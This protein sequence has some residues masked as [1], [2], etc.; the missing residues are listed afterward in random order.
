MYI[1]CVYLTEYTEKCPISPEEKLEKNDSILKPPEI[2]EYL[3]IPL[4]TLYKL[5]NEGKVPATR[6][7]KHWRFRKKEIDKWFAENNVVGKRD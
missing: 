4:R 6:V 7:G 3:R 2:A 5:C 1:N